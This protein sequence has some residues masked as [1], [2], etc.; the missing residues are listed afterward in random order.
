MIFDQSKDDFEPDTF[1]GEPQ[2]EAM[3]LPETS[4]IDQY[5]GEK[6]PLEAFP[7]KP[8]EPTEPQLDTFLEGSLEPAEP[9][10]NPSP[11]R[12]FEPDQ[13]PS[14]LPP[15]SPVEQAAPFS[16]TPSST[17]SLMEVILPAE[18]SESQ[19]DIPAVN[20]N[21]KKI[22]AVGGAKG[23]GSANPCLRPIWRSAWPF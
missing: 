11:V 9:E 10:L 12:L 14:D 22:I 1:S 13:P 6:E 16:E 7:A 20:Q 23:G 18:N 8:L 4:S 21:H 17:D 3:L 2:E 15:V 5:G 19:P